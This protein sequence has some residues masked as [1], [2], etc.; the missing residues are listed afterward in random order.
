[1][2]LILGEFKTLKSFK[3]TTWK[4]EAILNLDGEALKLQKKINVGLCENITQ[5][6]IKYHFR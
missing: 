3:V 2:G 1:M 5:L 6:P 4:I